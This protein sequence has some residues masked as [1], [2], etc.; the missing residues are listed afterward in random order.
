MCTSLL[1][2][3]ILAAAMSHRCYGRTLD[4]CPAPQ[5]ALLESSLSITTK[6]ALQPTGTRVFVLLRPLARLPH[7]PMHLSDFGIS[8]I[9][10]SD[11]FQPILILMLSRLHVGL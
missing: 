6:I 4:V 10:P 8:S 9:Q 7:L 11:A 3:F 1:K 2:A 5:P